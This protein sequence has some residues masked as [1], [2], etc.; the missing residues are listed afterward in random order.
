M[1]DDKIIEIKSADYQ[2]Y[3]KFGVNR[4][5]KTIEHLEGTTSNPIV[6]KVEEPIFSRLMSLLSNGNVFLGNVT[7]FDHRLYYKKGTIDKYIRVI[8]VGRRISDL[9]RYKGENQ[10]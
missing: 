7:Q 8:C 10:R 1:K 4:L 3:Y 6:L 2:P 9:D 5:I